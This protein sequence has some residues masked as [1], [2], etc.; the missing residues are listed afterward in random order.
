MPAGGSANRMTVASSHTGALAGRVARAV[1]EAFAP[2]VLVSVLLVVVGWHA[3]GY[4]PAGAAWGLAAA[5]FAAIIPFAVILRGV[6]TGTLT[7]HHVGRREQRRGPMLIALGCLAAGIIGMIVLGAERE[8]LAALGAVLIGLT[9]SIAVTS[10]WKI[11]VHAD[12]TASVVVVLV[13]VFGPA[14]LV[15]APIVLLVAWSRV[16]L[17]DHTATQT[18]VG[19]VV[20]VVVTAPVFS[21]LG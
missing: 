3:Y 15:T 5:A 8:L 7:D 13:M 16:H 2:A 9:V 12:V 18:A 6:R 21:V 17:G 14:M 20:G 1:T 19:A 4:S 10:W 11:S